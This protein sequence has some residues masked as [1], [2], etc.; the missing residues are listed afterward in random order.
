MK[1]INIISAAI[2]AVS[3]LM[4]L[5]AAEEESHEYMPMI[6][7]DRVWEYETDVIQY[8]SWNAPPVKVKREYDQW[9]FDGTMTINGKEYHRMVK[10]RRITNLRGE[11]T[12][13]D[14][15]ETDGAYPEEAFLREE[16]RRVY[17]A[18]T[19]S[20]DLQNCQMFD[21]D[22]GPVH[23]AD[24]TG[25][26]SEILLYDFNLGKGDSFNRLNVFKGW[27]GEDEYA[28]DED[29]FEYYSGYSE[30]FPDQLGFYMLQI[31]DSSRDTDGRL[32]Q[33]VDFGWR[34][35]TKRMA[36]GIGSVDGC[37]LMS[38]GDMGKLCSGWH[39]GKY[40]FCNLNN[41]YDLEGNITYRGSDDNPYAGV[42]ETGSGLS[43]NAAAEYYTL[44]GIRL[45]EPRKG[46]VC[47]VRGADGSARKVLF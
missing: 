9:R 41:Q 44:Q 11:V 22:A 16:D 24:V 20:I 18:L 4:T 40:E 13:T 46:E 36:E 21:N 42:N 14:F 30:F 1:H 34:Q 29:D 5:S 39:D 8:E 10:F 38:L 15:E 6:R 35:E 31:K 33:T 26:V 47:I 17:M 43:S 12:V 7:E 28:F 3:P 45:S 2:L 19:V 23:D 27:Y 37:N 32:V 25:K